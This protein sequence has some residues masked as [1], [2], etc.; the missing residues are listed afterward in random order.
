MK[1]LST[2]LLI[3]TL[4]NGS[5]SSASLDTQRLNEIK[6][7]IVELANSYSG[8]GDPDQSK[9]KNF[10]GLIQELIQ[11]NPMSPIRD[12]IQTL[13]GTWKQVWGPYEFRKD[14]GSIDP[15]IGIDEIYQVV[16]A[17]GYYYNVAPYFPSGDRSQEQVGLLRGEYVLDENDQNGLRVK[18]TDYPGVDPR[19]KDVPIW[20]LAPL[21]EAGLLENQITIVPSWVVQIFFGGGK[22]EEVYTDEDLRIVYGSKGTPASRRSLFIMTRVKESTI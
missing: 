16:S 10:E 13:A 18:F 3:V 2:I 15:T 5:A 6:T 8:Q 9:Q 14:D 22:L 21:A 20:S 7:Q 12:R 17:E 1:K 4:L 19:P 11:T